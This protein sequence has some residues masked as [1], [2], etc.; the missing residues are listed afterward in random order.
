MPKLGIDEHKIVSI[1]KKGDQ[2]WDFIQKWA[3]KINTLYE[4]I[5]EPNLWFFV[6][7]MPFF[8]DSSLVIIFNWKTDLGDP[9]A[10]LEWIN[11][12]YGTYSNRSEQLAIR[13]IDIL[14]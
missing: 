10:N 2:F 3:P 9:M 13:N 7:K 11:I 1:N 14:S 8:L 6:K 4:N 12:L 5:L